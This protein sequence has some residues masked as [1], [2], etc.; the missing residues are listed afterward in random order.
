M[1]VNQGWQEGNVGWRSKILTRTLSDHSPI[2]VPSRKVVN[3][4]KRLKQKLKS[5]SFDVF[6]NHAQHLKQLVE[7]MVQI[8]KDQENNPSDSN[9]Q[10]MEFDKAMEMEEA[11]K[12]STAM[13]KE[14]SKLSD[15][16]EGERNIA[17]FH[18]TIQMRLA[19]GQIIEITKIRK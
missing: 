9:L 12:V 8:L 6:G 10:Q 17:Y 14:K 7:E 3:K 13:A 11:V 18:V 19:K 16:F 1:L 2:D 15:A 4:L 5:L